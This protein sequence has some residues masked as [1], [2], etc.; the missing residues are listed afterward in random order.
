MCSVARRF[1]SRFELLTARRE[2]PR[3]GYFDG[4]DVVMGDDDADT[5]LGHARQLWGMTK[6]GVRVIIA[7]GDVMP[8]NISHPR[9]FAP[10]RE[11]LEA[12]AEP[13]SAAV[14]I[15]E[16]AFAMSRLRYATSDS[17]MI[18]MS[19]GEP[20]PTLVANQRF[21]DNLADPAAPLDAAPPAGAAPA[22][23][24]LKPGPVSVF[25]SRKEGRLFVRKGFA[26]VFDA[27]V[28]FD[29]PERPLGTHVFG[30][31]EAAGDKNSVRWTV[32]SIPSATATA[33]SSAADALDR[34][35]IP[36]DAV[37][38]ISNLMSPGASLIISDQGLGPETGVGTDFIVLTR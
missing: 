35:S 25:I 6:P 14:Q 38:R 28:T 23:K 26:P 20:R 13:Y 17:A 8:V 33:T 7:R 11:P 10:H 24:P 2:Q 29:H 31:Y 37:E 19:F 22:Q 30:A 27:A 3:M 1:D 36:Q 32:V 21:A 34:I 18:A 5:G 4:R 9:L 16:V 15:P 12:K